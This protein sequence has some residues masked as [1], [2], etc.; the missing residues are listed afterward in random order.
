MITKTL[1]EI[2]NLSYKI[3]KDNNHQFVTVEHLLYS[4]L[5][6]EEGKDIIYNCGGDVDNLKANLEM[7]FADYID[8]TNMAP[9]ETL[10][11]E[12]VI[13]NTINNVKSA[14][15]E[16]VRV[17]DI[18]ISIF[19]EEDSFA[20]Y[21]LEEEER[22]SKIDI[23]NYVEH[24]IP[25]IKE[26][27]DNGDSQESFEDLDEEEVVEDNIPALKKYT[28]ELVSLAKKGKIDPVIGREREF[29][30]I[31]QILCRRKKNNPILVGEPGVGK[32]A[33]VEGLA[34]K[35]ANRDVPEKLLNA[36]IFSLDMGALVAGTKYRG[37]F[38]KRLKNIIAEILQ[39]K[40]PI[41]FIDEIHTLVGAGAASSGTLD[42]SNILKPLL[43]E[44]RVKCIGATTY[45]EYRNGFEKDR[46][47][48]RRFQKIDVEQPTLTEAVKILHGLKEKYET[49]HA[50]KYSEKALEAAVK[51]SDKY[52]QGR[53][54]PD[55]AID[56]IDEAGAKTV[57]LK[58][59]KEV[60]TERDIEKVVS[61]MSRMPVNTISLSYK[62]KIVNL[63]KE[64]KN[65][66]F[67]Q[68]HAIETVVKALK[69][70]IAGLKDDKKPIGSFLFTGPTGVGKTELAVQ[71]SYILGI[72]F[73]RFDMS[74]YMEKHAVA[75]LIGS[76]PGYVGFEQGGQLTEA[77]NK[78]PHTV[79][80]FD[81]IEKAHNDIY[82][83]LLQIMDYGT[84]TDNMGKKINFRNVILIITSNSGARELSNKNIG[85][86]ESDLGKSKKAIENEFPPEFRN[87]LDAIVEFTY[88]ENEVIFKI[89][90]KFIN[91]LNEK[92][93]RKKIFV[94]LSNE[95]KGYI[96][97]K[98][99]DK[100]F[101]ARPMA[102]VIQEE[103]T[104][105]LAELILSSSLKKGKIVKIDYKDNKLVFN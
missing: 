9:V 18:L 53:F 22:I 34:L 56:V 101:G 80:L 54:L 79:L 65:Y 97:K 75:R 95:A 37:D 43:A 46:A 76:P 83:I 102:R 28:V 49:F 72:N 104:D 48:S 85:F 87:R 45:E 52:I 29:Q 47:L 44:G 20:R 50:I 69:R 6:T 19:N 30:R 103:I 51:L 7:Y 64:L 81:E 38:E 10:G 74:E 11:V 70:N 62:K 23:L 82:N 42:A 93:K 94:K 66:I 31:I 41:L 36:K 92:L 71:L 1:N 73:L 25:K 91:E 3:A 27:F 2:F 77:V 88:L 60:I 12:R 78:N 57:T 61:L 33:I 21:F 89:V 24:G 96:A 15:L 99:Y 59:K 16:K 86:L 26:H 39:E 5:L 40:N 105:K 14:G 63:E 90:D 4:V 58:K 8:K 17:G 98:G 67:G 55:K 13:S 100:Y 32:T 84:L 68:N 35:I